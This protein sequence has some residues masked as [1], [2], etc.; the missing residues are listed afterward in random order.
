MII[1]TNYTGKRGPDQN[2]DTAQKA[3]RIVMNSCRAYNFVMP[4]TVVM[5]ENPAYATI[6]TQ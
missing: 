1:I 2:E 6:R 4:K 5:E 3:E